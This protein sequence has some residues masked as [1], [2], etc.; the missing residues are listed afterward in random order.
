MTTEWDY[1]RAREVTAPGPAQDSAYANCAWAADGTSEGRD[2]RGFPA[3][4]QL[5]GGGPGQSAHQ[6]RAAAHPP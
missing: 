2:D 5:S 1:P 6:Q 4:G 3:T